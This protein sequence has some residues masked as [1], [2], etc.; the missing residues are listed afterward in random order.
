MTG[1]VAMTKTTDAE[2]EEA[3]AVE[4]DDEHTVDELR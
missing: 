2:T 3:Y 4:F 1:Q